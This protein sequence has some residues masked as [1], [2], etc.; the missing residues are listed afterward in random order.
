MFHLIVQALSHSSAMTYQVL[1]GSAG[2]PATPAVL[3][4]STGNTLLSVRVS[5]WAAMAISKYINLVIFP[6]SNSGSDLEY[7]VFNLPGEIT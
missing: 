4:L 6:S 2:L 1:P 5:R 3:A 7:I